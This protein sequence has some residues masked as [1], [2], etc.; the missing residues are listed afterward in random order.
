M[1]LQTLFARKGNGSYFQG[2]TFHFNHDQL[3]KWLKRDWKEMKRWL[4]YLWTQRII[5]CLSCRWH[6]GSIKKKARPVTPTRCQSFQRDEKN[7]S[8]WISPGSLF[9]AAGKKR[10]P[11]LPI[12]SMYGIF[13][14]MSFKNQPN[15]GIYTIHGWYGLVCTSDLECQGVFLQKESLL[16]CRES[17]GEVQI[18]PFTMSW[19]HQIFDALVVSNPDCK[20][21]AKKSFTMSDTG[22]TLLF[23]Q[24]VGLMVDS[25]VRYPL[26]LGKRN[27]IFKH[28]RRYVSSQEVVR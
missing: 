13:T 2:S 7:V 25:K 12:P 9:C 27:I 26:H 8:K 18:F 24:C 28:V 16:G 6:L 15:V 14:Y 23:K 11:A 4:R 1:V 3:E 17:V 5:M 20:S 10:Q 21:D 22:G 19:F